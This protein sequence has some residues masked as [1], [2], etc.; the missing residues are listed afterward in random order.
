MAREVL[1]RADA[2]NAGLLIDIW[3]YYNGG[4]TPETVAD[5]P[6]E[7]IT[8]VQLNDGPLVHEDFLT[9]ARAERK[10]P[11]EGELDVVGLIRAAHRAGYAGPYCVE[12]N[13]PEFRSL[14]VAE[15]ARRAAD[16]A[17]GVLRTAGVL[18]P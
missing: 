11:G 13:T 17:F 5:L 2:P 8:G 10:L 4:G 6:A 16:A 7:G 9:H 12:S 18:M 15:A 14:P 3:H 1:R